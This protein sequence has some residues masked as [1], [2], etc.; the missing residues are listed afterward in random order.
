MEN[1]FCN[2]HVEKGPTP[3]EARP[4]SGPVPEPFRLASARPSPVCQLGPQDGGGAPERLTD[5]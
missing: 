5:R 1:R 3:A 2:F 4:S